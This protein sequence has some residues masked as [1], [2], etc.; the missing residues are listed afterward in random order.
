MYPNTELEQFCKNVSLIRKRAKLSQKGMARIMHISVQ[1]LRLLESGILPPRF[2][3]DS[4]IYLCRAFHM[5][6]SQLLQDMER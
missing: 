5:K 6:P 2:K 4:L 3:I 1:T